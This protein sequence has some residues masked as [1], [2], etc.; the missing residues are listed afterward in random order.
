MRFHIIGVSRG[1]VVEILAYACPG[2]H[3]HGRLVAKLAPLARRPSRP[4][5]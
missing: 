2:P 3:R 5:P 4:D 1:S